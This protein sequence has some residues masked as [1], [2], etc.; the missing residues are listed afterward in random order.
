MRGV[1]EMLKQLGMKNGV[2]KFRP[3]EHHLAHASSAGKGE[4][5]TTFFGYGENGRIR[6]AACMARLPSILVLTCWM[7]SSR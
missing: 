2:D 1:M 7:V 5:A 4:Y 3:V 6:S